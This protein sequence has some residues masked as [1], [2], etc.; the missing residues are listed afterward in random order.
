VKVKFV[1]VERPIVSKIEG[2]AHNI[3][4]LNQIIVLNEGA[5]I[6]GGALTFERTHI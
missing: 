2:I 4:I 5:A 6:F 3:N 1:V